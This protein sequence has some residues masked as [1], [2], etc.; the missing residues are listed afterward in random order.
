M[1]SHL[2]FARYCWL[3]LW[4]INGSVLSVQAQKVHPHYVDGQLYIKLKPNATVEWPVF[5]TGQPGAT[6]RLPP[7]LARLHQQFGI[8]DLFKPAVL[9]DAE[10]QRYW[11]VHFTSASAV[12]AFIAAAQQLPSV[13]LAERVPLLRPSL[14]KPNDHSA[15]TTWHLHTIKA[16]DGWE[17]IEA[18]YPNLERVLVAIVDDAV[19]IDHDDLKANIWTNPKEIPGNN[20]DDDFNGF[21]DDVNGYDL[22]DLDNDPRPAGTMTHGTHC[23]GI[24][25]AVTDNGKGVAAVSWNRLWLLPVK[26]AGDASNGQ[27]IAA[28]YEGI[29]YAVKTGAKVISCS[30]GGP[31]NSSYS[32][33]SINAARLRGAIVIAAAGNDD[34]ELGVGVGTAQFPCM[35]NGVL[36][37]GATASNDA[38]T[39]YSN[40]GKAIDVCAPGDLYSTVSYNGFNTYATFNGTSMS[41]PLVAGAAA[42]LYSAFPDMNSVEADRIIRCGCD[43]LDAID[44]DFVG[45]LGHGRINLKRMFQCAERPLSCS[46]VDT[47]NRPLNPELFDAFMIGNKPVAS[48][49]TTDRAY[50]MTFG[51]YSGLYAIRSVAVRFAQVPT[52]ASGAVSFR[53]FTLDEQGRPSMLR[54]DIAV[55]LNAIRADFEAGLPTVAFFQEPLDVSTSFA[56]VVQHT[57]TNEELAIATTSPSAV[58]SSADLAWVRSA[59]TWQQLSSVRND[60][61]VRL[62]IFPELVNLVPSGIDIAIDASATEVNVN[63]SVTFRAGTFEADKTVTTWYFGDSSNT[64]STNK[65]PRY[66]FTQPGTYWV[67]LE[68][69]AGSCFVYDSVQ[70]T[71][72]GT[73]NRPAF[74]SAD[75]G[76]SWYPNP[77]STRLYAQ[78]TSGLSTIRLLDLQGRVVLEHAIQ[79]T[80][81]IQQELELPDALPDGLY[82]LELTS[83]DGNRMRDK[84]KLVR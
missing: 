12:E 26:A 66:A 8:T 71:V 78:A 59:N 83:R 33:A 46:A 6:K 14:S 48:F 49:N 68:A 1:F 24:A 51:G 42:L 64:K 75:A 43:N 58:P 73:T 45:K 67:R 34:M 81:A 4:L 19:A 62:A 56:L 39:G 72:R 76:F 47:L 2:G 30:W 79:P 61:N 38:K 23:A 82:I 36:C 44:P 53:V 50:A 77:A 35:I 22:A 40:Y 10:L 5:R 80:P 16:F 27:N 57:D 18:N 52:S 74:G 54:S 13:E 7:E 37:V 70:I 28:G 31:G 69:T 65:S 60:Q 84:L 55:T 63:E 3:V 21:V 25:G 11:K 20:R 29:Q 9:E 41:T 32:V 17:Y 15:Q